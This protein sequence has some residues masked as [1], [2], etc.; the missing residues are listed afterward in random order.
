MKLVIV[1]GPPGVGKLT[2]ARSLSRMTGYKV[3]HTHLIVD[4]VSTVFSRADIEHSVWSEN[5]RYRLITSAARANTAGLI[6]TFSFGAENCF[7]ISED[8]RFIKKVI[9]AVEAE[10][11][12]TYLIKLSCSKREIRK[13][14]TNPERRR[15]GKI[16]SYARYKE[17]A[18]TSDVNA[19][20]GFRASTIIDN[21][22]LTPD[23]VARIIHKACGLGKTLISRS[24]R[25]NINSRKR[26]IHAT[27]NNTAGS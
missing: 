1:Y 4:L 2:V 13:R 12:Q 22:E 20:V 3:L 27:E 15:F 16:C 8:T 5:L 24:L 26:E 19:V 25:L 11:G 17:I 14:I 10:A 21:T 7:G 6:I 18:A 23:Q 9:R